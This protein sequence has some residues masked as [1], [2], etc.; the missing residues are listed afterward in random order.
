MQ[1]IY[2]Q[3]LAD[4]FLLKFLR[5][6]VVG[7][8]GLFVDFGITWLL[9]EYARWQKYLSNAIGFIAAASSNYMLNRWWTFQ[10]TNP[11]VAGEY[12]GFVFIALLGLIINTLMLWLLVSRVRMNFYISKA[13]A[14][15]LVMVWN[16]VANL[17]FTFNGM[18]L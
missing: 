1:T 14:T 11:N 5:F 7:F 2:L 17:V 15:A 16:F 13:F 12:I 9:K 8:S 18:A 3:L 4:S 10:S 6:G